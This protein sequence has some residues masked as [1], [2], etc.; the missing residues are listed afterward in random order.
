[1]QRACNMHE[2]KQPEPI[3]PIRCVSQALSLDA[4]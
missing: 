1:M 3:A 4:L 2:V